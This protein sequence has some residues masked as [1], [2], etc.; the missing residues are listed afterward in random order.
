MCSR[1]KRRSCAKLLVISS[2]QSTGG[3]PRCRVLSPPGD[4]SHDWPRVSTAQR[5]CALG[6]TATS[7][8]LVSATLFEAFD[9]EDGDDVKS[10]NVRVSWTEKGR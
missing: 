10:H 4:V 7:E 2:Q 6:Q 5:R 9:A 3:T 8:K 1:Q